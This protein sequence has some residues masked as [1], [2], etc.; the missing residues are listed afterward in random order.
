MGDNEPK[1]GR[2]VDVGESIKRA[3]YME[4]VAKQNRL[5]KRRM[6][7]LDVMTDSLRPLREKDT[8]R[9]NEIME[10]IDRTTRAIASLKVRIK[11]LQTHDYE[12]S[13]QGSMF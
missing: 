9:M 8:E 5:M 10:C 2:Y 13:A 4:A 6:H 3:V 12:N 7:E 1:H 11:A